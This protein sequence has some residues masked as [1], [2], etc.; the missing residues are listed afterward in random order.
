MKQTIKIQDQDQTGL[1]VIMT[2]VNVQSQVL[3]IAYR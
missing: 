3:Y 2:I 1:Q